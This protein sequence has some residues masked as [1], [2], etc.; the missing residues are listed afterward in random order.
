MRAPAISDN[1]S[2]ALAAERTASEFV[3]ALT[4]TLP[5]FGDTI[6]VQVRLAGREG[7]GVAG[8]GGRV[9]GGAMAGRVSALV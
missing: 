3:A 4:A 8:R 6:T 2:P 1:P 9:V 7:G 5:A